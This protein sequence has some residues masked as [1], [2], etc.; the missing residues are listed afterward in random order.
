M[1]RTR[2]SPAGTRTTAGPRPRAACPS[3]W[4]A[5]VSCPASSP[6]PLQR[7]KSW[8]FPSRCCSQPQ[9]AN[10]ATSGRLQRCNLVKLVNSCNLRVCTVVHPACKAHCTAGS[11]T[12]VVE[13]APPG[14]P[15]HLNVLAGGHPPEA[16]AIEFAHAGENHRLRRHVE[17]RGERLGCK[18]HL[19]MEAAAEGRVS[20]SWRYPG[21]WVR[22]IQADT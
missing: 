12:S 16:A 13:A 19:H 22:T 6:P 5:P 11:C 1:Q 4:P 3:R 8:V 18:Q 17:P 9:S 7:C 20:G 10:Q 21:R 14:T 15:A 2:R